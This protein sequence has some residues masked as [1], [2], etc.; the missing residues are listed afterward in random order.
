MALQ[1][2]RGP[3]IAYHSHTIDSPMSGLIHIRQNQMIRNFVTGL[4]QSPIS[5]GSVQTPGPGHAT[6]GYKGSIPALYTSLPDLSRWQV[7]LPIRSSEV[8]EDRS[9]AVRKPRPAPN[10]PASYLRRTGKGLVVRCVD[11]ALLVRPRT[12][13][14]WFLW[15]VVRSADVVQRRSCAEGERNQ[16]EPLAWVDSTPEDLAIRRVGAGGR[17]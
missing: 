11:P 17:G 7:T 1:W 2:K 14:G 8:S 16:D 13:G 3:L 12:R 10:P 4:S 15:I 5:A 6:R 9:L